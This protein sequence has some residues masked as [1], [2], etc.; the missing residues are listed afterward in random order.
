MP[1]YKY[2]PVLIVVTALLVLSTF[3]SANAAAVQGNCWKST[4]Y[5]GEKNWIKFLKDN[6]FRN[7]M[8]MS[9]CAGVSKECF[10]ENTKMTCSKGKITW[11]CKG[12]VQNVVNK[13]HFIGSKRKD[14]RILN[15][16]WSEGY[17]PYLQRKW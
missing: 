9:T 11:P 13:V 3:T 10:G 15:E 6:D 4:H 17:T 5:T 12:R 2:A 14:V 7:G 1:L 8:F 16:K